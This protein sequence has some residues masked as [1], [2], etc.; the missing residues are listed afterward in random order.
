MTSN[1]VQQLIKKIVAQAGELEDAFLASDADAIIEIVSD[2]GPDVES[3]AVEYGKPAH[4][5]FSDTRGL[6]RRL[7][8]KAQALEDL[9]NARR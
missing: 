7:D 3:L 9:K 4:S 2:L 1:E 6:K 8:V 5:I